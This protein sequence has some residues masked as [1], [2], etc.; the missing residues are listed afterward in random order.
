MQIMELR[1]ESC[2]TVEHAMVICYGLQGA[3]SAVVSPVVS[4]VVSAVVS[5]VGDV[6]DI[7]AVGDVTDVGTVS[8]VSALSDGRS[9]LA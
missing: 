3:A 9:I 5:A 1:Q 7:D 8:A 6:S 2:R 4:P